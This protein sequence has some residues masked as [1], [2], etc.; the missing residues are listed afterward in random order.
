MLRIFKWFAPGLAL[1]LV[2]YLVTYQAPS[3]KASSDSTTTVSAEKAPSNNPAELLPHLASD[4]E[5]V[6]TDS[7]SD[8]NGDMA[9]EKAAIRYLYKWRD[10]ENIIVISSYPPPEGVS[11]ETFI[12]SEQLQPPVN[13]E[14]PATKT[15]VVPTDTPKFADTPLRVY[16]P[17]GLKELIEYSEE[18]GEKIQLRGEMLNELVE[19]L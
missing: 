13:E 17:E 2:I 3:D 7:P 1:A 9:K 18:I 4:N 8:K 15:Q 11:A 10:E 6:D 12:L 16:S 14:L 5:A 19:L